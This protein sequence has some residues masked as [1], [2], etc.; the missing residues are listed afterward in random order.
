M[1]HSILPPSSM[2]RISK[3][4]ASV[5]MQRNVPESDEPNE[6]RDIGTAVHEC[7]E[8]QLHG[9]TVEPG[10]RAENGIIITQEMINRGK[11]YV[12]LC[13]E[14]ISTAT[15]YHIEERVNIQRIHPDCFGTP[16]FWCYHE[17]NNHVTLIDYKDGW[18]NVEPE[19]NAQGIAYLA[20]IFDLFNADE[21]T[22]TAEIII[23]QPRS[24]GVKRWRM[25]VAGLRPLINQ[26]SAAAHEALS[27]NP[28]ARAG[29]HC[30]YCRARAVCKSLGNT[31]DNF[32]LL[33]DNIPFEPNL[34]QEYEYLQF[35][36]KLIKAK[37][38]AIEAMCFA[39]P[40]DG[41]EVGTGRG[42]RAWNDETTARETA[43]LYGVDIEK[44]PALIT[45]TQ[46]R[47]A[48][49]P[50]DVIDMLSTMSPGKPT[51][52]KINMNALKDAFGK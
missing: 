31:I 2:A 19:N 42:R 40:P 27:D 28:T 50:A 39:S 25:S 36:E 3:C 41:Y 32:V 49:I 23:V 11:T 13:R 4:P 46:A 12:D 10:Y 6:V 30:K 8:Q 48:G 9:V 7:N 15:E 5:P 21:L 18:V 29:E 45:P 34:G 14:L 1:E 35:A 37:L 43:M 26:Y 44:A 16:D 24:G 17:G 33:A 22:A 38:T 47:N 52:Q 20:G 51:L